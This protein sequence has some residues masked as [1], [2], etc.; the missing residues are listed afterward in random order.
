MKKDNRY[1]PAADIL[2][3]I[4]N[5]ENAP[6]IVARFENGTE[7]TYSAYML[8]MLK[9]DAATLDI[10][11]AAT[12]ELLYTRDDLTE[13]A[14]SAGNPPAGFTA[15]ELI[16]AITG[17]SALTHS[18]S[19][20]VPSTSGPSTPATPETVNF[21]KSYTMRELSA[22]FGGCTATPGAGAWI[23]GTGKLISE[24]VIVC[25]SYAADV[26]PEDAQHVKRI[27]ETL[28]AGMDQDAITIT[29]DGAAGFVAR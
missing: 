14:P 20:T 1:N 24:N 12:G 25:T 18:V 28:R 2:D 27:A 6:E 22:V 4:G 23:D 19:I 21:W 9:T 26:T 15:A 11:D 5:S 3:A 16:A 8:D 7:A 13:P 29:I 10:I 17:D